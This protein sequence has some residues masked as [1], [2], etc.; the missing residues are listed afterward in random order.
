MSDKELS[1]PDALQTAFSVLPEMQA[2]GLIIHDHF[3]EL[4]ISACKRL[5]DIE[6]AVSVLTLMKESRVA[7]SHRT[8]GAAILTC[9]KSISPTAVET[10]VKLLRLLK[11]PRLLTYHQVIQVCVY[12]MRMDVARLLHD[13][14]KSDGIKPSGEFYDMLAEGYLKVAH[15]KYRN[16]S[17]DGRKAIADNNSINNNNNRTSASNKA[18]FDDANIAAAAAVGPGGDPYGE[19]AI[20]STQQGRAHA[21]QLERLAAARE[22]DLILQEAES[23]GI[24]PSHATYQR[25]ADVYLREGAREDSKRLLQREAR[26]WKSSSP[27]PSSTSA[28]GIHQPSSLS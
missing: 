19:A 12:K 6:K 15:L 20:S 13:R 4:L 8:I 16:S 9:K 25:V 17:N 10:A 27:I 11:R 14:L 2:K 18:I 23:I 21:L 24:R 26:L 28:V 22:A 5:G 7:P 3:G 1:P